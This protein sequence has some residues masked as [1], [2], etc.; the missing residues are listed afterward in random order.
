MARK[1]RW[2]LLSGCDGAYDAVRQITYPNLVGYAD[3]HDIAHQLRRWDEE[4][5]SGI[6]L[7]WNRVLD[8]KRA[9]DDG[10]DY[11]FFVD[12][13]AVILDR[14]EWIGDAL[15]PDR[16]IHLAFQVLNGEIFPSCGVWVVQN[17]KLGHQW[18][19]TL[20]AQR[21]HYEGDPWC[22]QGVAYDLLGFDSSYKA[23][24]EAGRPYQVVTEWTDYVGFLPRRWHSTPQDPVENPILFHATGGIH[25]GVQARV[26]QLQSALQVRYRELRNLSRCGTLVNPSGKREE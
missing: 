12:S 10:F 24:A 26:D 4:A 23:P 5:E 1:P 16:S 8:T 19:D 15:N 3:R 7:S 14:F 11:V 9:L 2:V 20:L 6:Q 17:T 18:C 22:E 13:D 21:R 25:K